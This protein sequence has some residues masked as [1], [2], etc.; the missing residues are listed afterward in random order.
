MKYNFKLKAITAAVLA[1]C[2]ANTAYAAED[3]TEVNSVNQ[4]NTAE[5]LNSDIET[6]EITGFRGSLQKAMN[7][8]RF[9]QTVSDSIHAEDIG[10]STDQNIA[11]ALSRVTGVTVTEQDGEGARIS[12]RGA[13]PSMNQ[14]TMNGVALTGGLSNPDGGTQDNS[15]DLSTFSADILSSIDVVKTAAAD[16]DEGSLGGS[17]T[18]RTVKPLDLRKDRLTATIEGRYNKYADEYDA[19][20]NGSFSKKFFDDQ[21]GVILTVSHDNQKTRQDRIQS[22]YVNGVLPIAD[23]EAASG[24]KA[25]DLNGKQIRVLGYSSDDEENRT[26]NSE[27]TLTNYDPSAQTIIT[28]D[29]AW[30]TAKEFYRIGLNQNE[31][32]RTSLSAGFQFRPTENIDI[33]LDLTHTKQKQ[34]NDN[35]SLTLNLSPANQLQAD[36]DINVVDT[37]THTIEE[38]YGR[39]FTGG[40]N[41][42]SGMRELTTDVASLSL[43]YHINDNLKMDLMLGYSKTLDETPDQN[44]PDAYISMNTATWGTAGREAVMAMPEYE[45]VG[46]NCTQGDTADCSIFTGTTPGVFD[47]FDGTPIDVRS[48]FNPFDLHHNH[49]GGFTFRNNKLTDENKSLFLDFDYML[50]MDHLVS[51]EF[52]VKYAKRLRDVQ[53]SNEQVTNSADLP[54][55]GDDNAEPPRGMGTINVGDILANERFPYDNFAVDIQGDRSSPLFNGWPMLDTQKALDIIRG[56]GELVRRLDPAGTR[57]IETKTQA[58]YLKLNFEAMDGKLTGN[59]GLRKVQDDNFARGLGDITY[60]NNQQ[61]IDPYELLVERNLGDMSQQ[62]CPAGEVGFYNGSSDWRGTPQ[63]QDQLSNCWAWQITHAYTRNNADTYPFDSETQEWLLQGPDGVAQEDINRVLWMNSDG[64]IQNALPVNSDFVVYTN[65]AGVTTSTNP[66]LWVRFGQ[67]AN[68]PIWPFISRVTSRL[69]TE[70]GEP[71]AVYGDKVW[72]R[73]APTSDT[74]TIDAVLPSLNLNFAVNEETILRFAASKTITR[75]RID[76]RNPS[77]SIRENQWGTSYGDAGNTQLDFLES[78]NLDASFEWYFNPTGM[79]SVALFNKDM[80]GQEIEVDTPYHYKDVKS[81]YTLTDTDILIP[82]DENRV[83]G[84]ADQCHAHRYPA[85]W[86]EQWSIDCDVAVINQVQNATGSSITGLEI[87]YTQNYDFLPGLLSGLGA[88]I[89]YT[90]QESEQ[91]NIDIGD[92]GISIEGMPVELTPQHSANTTVFWE[93]D[94]MNLRF[95]HRY[96]G[97]QLINGGVLGGAIW[98]DETHRLDIS[99]SYKINNNF[100]VTLNIINALDDDRRLFHTIRNATDATNA[101][102][103]TIR[104]NEGNYFDGGGVTTRTYAAYKTGVQYRAGLRITF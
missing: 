94:G 93:K 28:E 22:D 78:T 44:S 24:R 10:K 50:D 48:R 79:V 55:E 56:D 88:S 21:F 69:T 30:A 85:G 66:G 27:D 68:A 7:A 87:G 96:T 95:A 11:D 83:P 37:S 32:E 59:I 73:F 43:D 47:A 102:D 100:S 41:R 91:D 36:T 17:V 64:T 29:D 67:P 58:A 51:V 34:D 97:V 80:E 70:A 63:N 81:E 104:V 14:I 15:V 74:S 6:I 53:V 103:Q 31:R 1:S 40:F 65:E 61:I 42:T 62:P 4:N 5:A 101:S 9:S 77:K 72:R 89:N 76:S 19:R 54:A 60:I 20:I 45:L 52:G 25:T 3:D 16:Q 92:T 39:S 12:I 90:Y 13:G 2:F 57:S 71:Y 8:K 38:M 26:L 35:H 82:Y 46:Y 99:G 86:M 84:D 49:L 33:Q 98:Q 75:P 23:W 18:L